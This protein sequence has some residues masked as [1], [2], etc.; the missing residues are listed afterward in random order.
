VSATGHF[1]VVR[2]LLKDGQ[3]DENVEYVHW[4]TALILA[5]IYVHWNTALILASIYGHLTLR[6]VD[7]VAKNDDDTTPLIMTKKNGVLRL[8]GGHT[9][10]LWT[11]ELCSRGQ[12][13]GCGYPDGKLYTLIWQKNLA[14][15]RESSIFRIRWKVWKSMYMLLIG[16]KRTNCVKDAIPW[17]RLHFV[18]ILLWE[19]C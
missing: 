9:D 19:E 13:L 5:S 18:N 3:V 4:N 10:Y 16:K 12:L 17:K 8:G 7:A 2:K 11:I 15:Q 6:M 1:R 14:F